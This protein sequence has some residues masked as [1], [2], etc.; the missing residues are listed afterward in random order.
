VP[1][2]SGFYG[3]IQT[4]SAGTIRAVWTMPGA[5]RNIELDI[6]AGQP[7]LGQP[8]PSIKKPPTGALA[9]GKGTVTQLDI[10]T[11]VVPAGTYTFYAYKPTSALVEST[12]GSITFRGTTCP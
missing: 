2:N 7:L 6:Y 11:A 9:T 5:K 3:V 1:K 4:T 10:T 12:T 8:N